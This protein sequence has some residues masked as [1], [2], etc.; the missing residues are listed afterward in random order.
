MK[1]LTAC[2]LLLVA[3]ILTLPVPG[4]SADDAK[5]EDLKVVVYYFHGDRRCKT[6][7]AIES[8][9]K[10]LLDSVFAE[11]MKSGTI[12]WRVRNTDEK[13]HAHFEKDFNLLFG[14]VVAV[15]MKDGKQ[16]EW[17]NLQKVWELVW[18]KDEFNSYLET[19]VK[20]YLAP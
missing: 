1:R 9:S 2:F 15:K 5:S 17:K 8:N 20:A 16:V 6:C 7:N 13:E 19:E 12:E 14:S 18:D 10:A 4:H 11:Q 3:L